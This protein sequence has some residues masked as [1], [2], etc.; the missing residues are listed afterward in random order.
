MP[1]A[2][3]SQAVYTDIDPDVVIDEPDEYFG[4]D[5]DDDGLNDFNFID[6]SYTTTV[7]YGDLANVKAILV[8]AFDT[9][10]NG[11][12][13]TY[14]TLSGGAGYIYYK[15]YALS[16]NQPVNNSLNF[17][18]AN[19]QTMVK[20][21]DE[22]SFT[23]GPFHRGN[24]YPWTGEDVTDHYLGFRFTDE[25]EIQR[26]GWIRCS[27]I[28]SGHTL[29]IHDYAYESKPGVGILT[30]DTIGDTSTVGLNQVSFQANVYSFEKNIYISLPDISSAEISV[31][32]LNGERLIKKQMNTAQDIIDMSAFSSG[33]YLI[34]VVQKDK[35]FTKKIVLE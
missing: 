9:I 34:I 15:P 17:Y 29:I 35:T 1:A 24:W 10:A 20:E 14:F 32:N 13:G 16:L 31:Y 28:D 4:I 26:Y 21:M 8:G 19:Y 6:K 18:N 3:Y 25:A 30:G 33:I 11:I 5:L 22:F 2:V 23:S 27:V 7:F 12:A